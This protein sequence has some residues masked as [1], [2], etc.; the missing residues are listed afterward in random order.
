MIRDAVGAIRRIRAEYAVPP[1]VSIQATIVPGRGGRGAVARAFDDTA[2]V[3]R[4]ARAS[5]TVSDSPPS[6]AAAHAVLAGGASLVVP[7]AGLVD[8]EKECARLRGEL[9]SLET[10]L[11]AL[12]ARLANEKFVAKARPEVVDA[13][14]R[15][16]SEWSERRQQ[17]REKVQS[18]CG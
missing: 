13:E 15:K 5:L 11:Q 12:E 1:A 8:V 16:L 6:G 17:L 18:L 7:L 4:L 2:I 10:Q 14:R 3:E 9:T